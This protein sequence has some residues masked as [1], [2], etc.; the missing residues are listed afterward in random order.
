VD[1]LHTH[2]RRA[3]LVARR[4]QQKRRPPILYTVHL[5]DISLRGPRRWLSDFGDH[6]HVAALQGVR[7]ATGEGRVPA[8]RV[9][10]IPHGVHVEQFPARTEDEKRRARAALG[11][12]ADDR[13]ALYVGRLDDPKNEGWL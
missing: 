4:L 1:V 10:F 9:T 5:T 3:T 8:D 7:W 2:Y 13:V 11:L 12:G 6:T